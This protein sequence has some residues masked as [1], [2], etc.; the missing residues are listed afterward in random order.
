MVCVT[1]RACKIGGKNYISLSDYQSVPI[2]CSSFSFSP[3]M[4]T[5][6]RKQVDV[7]DGK[8]VRQRGKTADLHTC[9]CISLFSRSK[10][11]TW[12]SAGLDMAS[13]SK[14]IHHKNLHDSW[15]VGSSKDPRIG[16]CQT[17]LYQVLDASISDRQQIGHHM[18]IYTVIRGLQPAL[19]NLA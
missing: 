18:L 3:H 17:P 14:G 7:C 15:Q 19:T 10:L 16:Q 9:I 5:N 11:A 4:P 12:L 6:G 8:R 2:L 1:H 13:P